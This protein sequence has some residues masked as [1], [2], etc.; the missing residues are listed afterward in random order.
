LINADGSQPGPFR[1]SLERNSI[2]DVSRHGIYAIGAGVVANADN[3]SISG[4]GPA[5]GVPQFGIFLSTGAGGQVTGNQINEGTCGTLVRADCVNV[6]SE[7]VTLRA[8]ADGTIVDGNSIANAQS[9]IFI[10]GGSHVR[11]SNNF[12]RNIDALDGID[13]QGTASGFF[14]DSLIQGNTIYKAL[15]IANESCGI[16]E[17]P[18][19]GVARN[20]IVNNFVND[21]Y[22]GIGYVSADNANAG[23]FLNVLYNTFS[24]DL[25]PT[26]G[27]PP[28][29]P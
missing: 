4:I 13:I 27:P 24:T 10:N 9:G 7:G 8:V 19:T 22:C 20:S 5:S 21:A 26:G 25:Y 28:V 15:P 11:V 29:E 18:N 23:T 14:T 3:N 6:R 2:H 16:W 1:V 17:A 12:I